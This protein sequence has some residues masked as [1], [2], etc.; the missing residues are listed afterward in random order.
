MHQVLCPAASLERVLGNLWVVSASNPTYFQSRTIKHSI[1]KS[2]I[3]GE[4]HA[5]MSG[6]ERIRGID[7]IGHDERRMSHADGGVVLLR[8]THVG[9]IDALRDQIRLP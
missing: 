2:V 4:W 6:V 8:G 3:H 5:R 9:E 1:C 7:R